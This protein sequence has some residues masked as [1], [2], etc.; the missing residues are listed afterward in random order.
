MF[1]KILVPLDGSDLAERALPPALVL[2]QHSEAQLSLLRALAPERMLVADSHVLML[3]GYSA[4]WPNQSLELARK[5]ATDYLSA[6]RATKMPKGLRLST[7]MIEGDPA[8]IIVE[9]ARQEGVDLIVMSS[10]GYSGLTRW[11]LGSVAERVLHDAPC[12]VLIVRTTDPIRHVLIP[13]DGSEFS[14]QI[15]EPAFALAASLECK[16]TLSRVIERLSPDEFDY[17]EHL[18]NGLG[19]RLQSDIHT[20]AEQYLHGIATARRDALPELKTVILHGSPAHSLLEYAQ[21][22]GVDLIAMSTHG[23]TGLKRW[24]YGSVTEKILRAAAN[25]AM[26]V[27]RPA[28]GK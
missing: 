12:P 3:G 26:L 4:I 28:F 25:C 6:L 13:L 17:L 21:T 1:T 10:H 24:V 23:R 22:R 20:E 2:A 14:E 16:V 27:S 8:E 11:V 18:E 5:A 15:L 19:Q 9:T 7:E